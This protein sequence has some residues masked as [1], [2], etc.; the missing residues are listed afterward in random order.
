[1]LKILKIPEMFNVL[2][3]LYTSK[4]L[5]EPLDFLFPLFYLPI[6]FKKYISFLIY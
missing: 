2:L 3:I 5:I 1:M 4:I 6:F